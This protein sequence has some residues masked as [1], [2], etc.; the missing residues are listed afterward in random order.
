MKVDALSLQELVVSIREFA[1][2]NFRSIARRMVMN[3]G[4]TSHSLRQHVGPDSLHD[5][6]N[7]ILTVA[8]DLSCVSHCRQMTLN[9]RLQ[10]SMSS[11]MKLTVGSDCGCWTSW[12]EHP[13]YTCQLNFRFPLSI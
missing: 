1:E 2:S 6:K 9:V 3:A 7:G 10:V 13:S 12:L 11:V 5:V 8:T 4:T